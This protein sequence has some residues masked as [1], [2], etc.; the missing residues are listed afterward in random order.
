LELKAFEKEVNPERY[1]YKNKTEEYEEFYKD[2]V[3]VSPDN[4][5]PFIVDKLTQNAK[6]YKKTLKNFKVFRVKKKSPKK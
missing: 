3:L 6:S 2:F 4:K 5:I 1:K